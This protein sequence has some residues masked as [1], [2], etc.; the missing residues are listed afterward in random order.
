MQNGFESYTRFS[1]FGFG[2]ANSFTASIDDF[3]GI[4]ELEIVAG[5]CLKVMWAADLEAIKYNIYIR[6]DNPDIF[7]EEYLLG[8]FKNHSSGFTMSCA[9]NNIPIRFVNIRTESDGNTLLQDTKMYYIGVKAENELGFEDNN[10]A[11]LNLRPLGTGQAYVFVN[12]R[13]ISQVS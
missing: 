9:G 7:H 6:P 12:D 13:H 4:L 11:Y 5:G 10:V 8:K 2:W 3:E 1:I